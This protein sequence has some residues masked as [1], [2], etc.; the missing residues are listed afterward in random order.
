MN[1]VF[2]TSR[3]QKQFQTIFLLEFFLFLIRN[4]F[5]S[6][7]FTLKRKEANKYNLMFWCQVPSFQKYTNSISYALQSFK[8]FNLIFR[9][10]NFFEVNLG[11]S[12][13]K[14]VVPHHKVFQ[15]SNVV[16]KKFEPWKIF[17]F[18]AFR[19]IRHAKRNIWTP[20]NKCF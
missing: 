5:E 17:E 9:C 6:L 10:S 12:F 16:Q 3:W 4:Y 2:G 18:H 11:K 15:W 13:K 8:P 1:L 14:L 20:L 7:N 19:L